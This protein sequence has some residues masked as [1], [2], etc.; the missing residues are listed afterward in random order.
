[1]T[2]AAAQARLAF[3]RIGRDV[4][5]LV[6]RPDSEGDGELNRAESPF[7]RRGELG[8]GDRFTRGQ[9]PRRIR[10]QLRSGGQRD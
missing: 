4:S 3:D 2:D 1:M 9:Q 5:N 7:H 10:D 6:N 8:P